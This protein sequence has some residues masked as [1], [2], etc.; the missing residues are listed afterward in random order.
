MVQL[1]RKLSMEIHKSALV[2]HPAEHMFDLIEAAEHYPEFLPWC[3]AATVIE[4][5]DEVVVARIAINYHGVKFDFVTRNPKRRP[6]WMAI[7]LAQGPFRR[8][9]GD[10]HLHPLLDA[11]CKVEFNLRYE[12]ANPVMAKLAG[13]VFER[14]ANTLVDAFVAR[15]AQ[16]RRPGIDSSL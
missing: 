4:R 11:G 15:A 12:F 10:W 1:R 2:G 13:P 7:D 14:I 8:F 9:A 16:T 5:S 3:S 6:E